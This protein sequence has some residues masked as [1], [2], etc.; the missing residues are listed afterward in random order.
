MNYYSHRDYHYSASRP[1]SFAGQTPEGVRPLQ[2]YLVESH[3]LVVQYC[4]LSQIQETLCVE[5]GPCFCWP[6]IYECDNQ[7]V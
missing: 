3:D 4:H 6:Q 1:I 5:P 7:Y 2:V